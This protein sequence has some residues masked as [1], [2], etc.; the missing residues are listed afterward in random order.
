MTE[1]GCFRGPAGWEPSGKE[2]GVG[3]WGVHERLS[4]PSGF[5]THSRASS[6]G[7]GGQHWVRQA[8][9]VASPLP[10]PTRSGPLHSSL[11][12]LLVSQPFCRFA[13][14]GDRL[15]CQAGC[16]LVA[17]VCSTALARRPHNPNPQ[18]CC[19]PQAARPPCPAD[20]RQSGRSVLCPPHPSPAAPTSPSLG[21]A[22]P[23]APVGLGCAVLM[24]QGGDTR[25]LL[26]DLCCDVGA[27]WE[28]HLP[29]SHQGG[30]SAQ[31][32][33]AQDRGPRGGRTLG[34]A[35]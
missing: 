8:A 24:G 21:K 11:P 35:V 25:G 14:G 9:F 28:G 12:G 5:P 13:F 27:P 20:P 23:G 1:L 26:L 22:T 3:W 33:Q 31:S 2:A 17:L 19:P 6:E 18:V 7:P 4:P 29:A 15:L 10:P 34:L 16:L 30:C 32:T